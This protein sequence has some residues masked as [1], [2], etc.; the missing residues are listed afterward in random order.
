MNSTS[1]RIGDTVAI[2][3][4]YQHNAINNGP[5]VQRFWH[6][7]K[8]LAISEMLAPNPRDSVL[9]VGCGSGVIGSYLARS[10][11]EVIAIDGSHRAIEFARKT[12]AD[13]ANLK[14]ECCLVDELPQSHRPLDKIYCLELV[15]HITICQVEQLLTDC[16]DRLKPGGEIFLTTPNYR[17]M[18]PAIE[19]V[20][21]VLK[22]VPQLRGHQHVS[23]FYPKRLRETIEA[24]G[25]VVTDLRSNCL[26]SPWIAAFNWEWAK[27]V[28]RLEL[29]TANRLGSILLV[30]ARKLQGGRHA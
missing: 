6:L 3:G 11:G 20:M 13:Q 8:K 19:C 25:F 16:L 30:V 15:E 4:D 14:F 28:H 27:S 18:W 21:D 1:R 23:R 12:Y 5:A 2:P 7:S 26:F 22:L 9:D 10:A 29:S 24:A 17:S